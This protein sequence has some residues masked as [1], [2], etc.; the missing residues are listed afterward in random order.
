MD[1]PTEE[2]IIINW[3]SLNAK[4]EKA[5]ESY[6][7]NSVGFVFQEFNL[8]DNYTVGSNVALALQLQS[9]KA[10]RQEV[11]DVLR[12]VELVDGDGKT[13]YDRKISQLS[14]GQKQSVAIARALIK[15]P[16][17]IL[18]DEPTGALDSQTG[19][20][21]YKLF[22]KLSEEKLIIIVTHDEESAQKFGDRI[23]KLHDGKIVGDTSEGR[24]DM[25]ATQRARVP[26]LDKGRGLPYIRSL[27]LAIGSLCYKKFR[28][29][30]SII[31]SVITFVLFGI[32]LGVSQINTVNVELN[33]L[34]GVGQRTVLLQSNTLDRRFSEQTISQIHDYCGDMVFAVGGGYIEFSEYTGTLSD[35]NEYYQ[36]ASQPL[37][38]L[39][40]IDTN[41]NYDNI[42]VP[43]AR[44]S[45]KD[46]CRLPEA[47]NEIAITDL[48][49][50]LFI[51]YGYKEIDGSIVKING[52]DQLIGKE[53]GGFTIVGV[54]TADNTNAFL[55][56]YEDKDSLSDREKEI[57]NSLRQTIV[58]FGF[59]CGEYFQN[60]QTMALCIGL[61][62]D[63][64]TDGGFLN[65]LSDG[66]DKLSVMTQFSSL[67][68]TVEFFTQFMLVPFGVAAAVFAVF[69][70]LLLTNF[71]TISIDS[72][73]R[74]IG[75]LRALGATKGNIVSIC[76]SESGLI[77]FI[78]FILTL[79]FVAIF[80]AVFNMMCGLSVFII[81]FIQVL[82][83]FLLCF[84]IASVATILPL[85]RMLKLQ[86]VEIISR[87]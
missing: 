42:L 23:I 64:Y 70:T 81:S 71:L 30:L 79:I 5:L 7:N 80:G 33:T 53:L 35:L 87:Q 34:F 39:A 78:D 68:S 24:N 43:D 58:S 62:G 59:V 12:R 31:L 76:L 49:A 17:V 40:Q 84:G 51:K 27:Q 2:E 36:L 83:I 10:T 16:T 44:F 85:I 86:P 11:D 25:A 50:D 66:P 69:S 61:S 21:L 13:L 46:K 57:F 48:R 77:A 19:E 4:R 37:S 20:Q 73:K 54:Y 6:R 75:I 38:M 47:E 18:A 74:E 1:S 45:D 22:K 55:K 9:A 29:A 56:K 32:C 65:R 15:D 82:S 3:K 26:V 63:A 8:L 52:P 14:G 60:G 72:K 67:L 28:L 41:S